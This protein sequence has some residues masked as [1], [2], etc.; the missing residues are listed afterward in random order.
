MADIARVAVVQLVGEAKLGT[1]QPGGD[2]GDKFFECVGLVAKAFAEG[3]REPV[4]MAGQCPV[5]WT[6]TLA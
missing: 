1:D 6:L 5:S 4:A 3:A 2:L